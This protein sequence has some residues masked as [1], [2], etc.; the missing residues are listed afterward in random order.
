MSGENTTSEYCPQCASI[1]AQFGCLSCGWQSELPANDNKLDLVDPILIDGETFR[2]ERLHKSFQGGSRFLARDAQDKTV[3]LLICNSETFIDSRLEQQTIKP[4]AYA[5]LRLRSSVGNHAV[6]VFELS[7]GNALVG[8]LAQARTNRAVN[9]CADLTERISLPL[10]KFM[11]ALQTHGCTLGCHDP[12]E[13]WIRESGEIVLLDVPLLESCAKNQQFTRLIPAFSPPE[14]YGRCGGV[15]DERADVFFIGIVLYHCL[16]RVP[17]PSSVGLIDERLPP[18]GLFHP[19]VHPDLGAVVRKATSLIPANRYVNAASLV[20]ALHKSLATER[21]R[22]STTTRALKLD[23]ATETHIGLLKQRYCAENQDSYFTSWDPIGSRGLFIVSDGV[24]VSQFGSGDQASEAV[25][26]AAR[27]LW[28]SLD[29]R[30]LFSAD[31]TLGAFDSTM[32]ISADLYLSPLPMSTPARNRL[33]ADLL[34]AANATIG[35]RIEPTLPKS[36]IHPEGIM[37]ATAVC[38]L[39][40][41][42]RMTHCSIGDSRIYLIREN[43]VST[44]TFEHS[45]A[46]RLIGMGKKYNESTRVANAAALVRCVGEFEFDPEHRLVPVPLRPDFGE[47]YLLPGDVIILCS[48]GI[49][50]Y[51]ASSEEQAENLIVDMIKDSPSSAHLAYDLVVA[52]NRG[53]GGDN[54]TCTVIKV[55]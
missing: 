24:S 54:L 20:S 3:E 15:L 44:L 41:E 12:A 33:L 40:E 17:M 4:D 49:P 10:A 38:C 7:S 55:T 2:F 11:E 30:A 19:R 8:Q 1:V 6:A 28:S 29:N 37:A 5:P 50:D 51:M 42:N 52:A 27:A 43:N 22:N 35:I 18:P 47:L 14:A 23:I 31:E 45:Y 21:N 39:I 34:D 9:D 32:D 48:D 16:I 25:T 26:D 53:G 36:M 46:N 13:F